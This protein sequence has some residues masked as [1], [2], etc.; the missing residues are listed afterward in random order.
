[1][2]VGSNT[3]ETERIKTPLYTNSFAKRLKEGERES[4]RE[5]GRE[6]ERERERET[7]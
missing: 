2:G 5:R 7:E 6:G 1:L 3:D 4:E